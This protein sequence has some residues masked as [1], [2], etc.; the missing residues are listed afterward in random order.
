MG[1]NFIRWQGVSNLAGIVALCTVTG[2]RKSN[3]RRRHPDRHFAL[4]HRPLK[5]G[6][7]RSRSEEW[8]SI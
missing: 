8:C 7:H 5:E 4:C 6:R 2:A 3:V 1:M